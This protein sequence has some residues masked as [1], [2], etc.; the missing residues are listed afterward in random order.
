VRGGSVIA[1]L[2]TDETMPDLGLNTE[3]KDRFPRVVT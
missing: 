2:R 1:L 3:E